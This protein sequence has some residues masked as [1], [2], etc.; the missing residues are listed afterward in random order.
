MTLDDVYKNIN[1]SYCEKFWFCLNAVAAFMFDFPIINAFFDSED[2][3]SA[4][5]VLTLQGA[6]VSLIG[7]VLTIILLV[8]QA[9]SNGVS[10]FEVKAGDFLVVLGSL[11]LCGCF[12]PLLIVTS[13]YYICKYFIER[14]RIRKVQRMR[15]AEVI[16]MEAMIQ[17]RANREKTKSELDRSEERRL[18][19]EELKKS[20]LIR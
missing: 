2:G 9:H 5:G 14:I 16:A 7:L 17:S 4:S 1:N 11:L 6:F 13:P 18:I 10:L 15:D 19:Q 20:G 8:C 12:A 3:H